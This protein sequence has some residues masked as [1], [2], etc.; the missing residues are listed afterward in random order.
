MLTV[1]M[2]RHFP[3]LKQ[4]RINRIQPRKIS[5]IGTTPIV[6]KKFPKTYVYVRSSYQ[7]DD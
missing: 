5:G 3:K 2:A 7:L 6:E 1:I 4:G